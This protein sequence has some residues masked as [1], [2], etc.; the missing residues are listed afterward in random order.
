MKEVH[1]Y[2]PGRAELLGNHTD[3][4]EGFVLSLAVDYGTIIRGRELEIPRVEIRSENLQ[5][6]YGTDV[7][8]LGPTDSKKW[9]NYVLGVLA[10]L[11]EKGLHFGGMSM[12]ISSTIPLGAGLSSSAALE[13]G[14]ACFVRKLFPFEMNPIDIAKVAQKAEH[15]YAGVKCGLLD[16]ISSLMSRKGHVTFIDCRTY[17][18]RHFPL[19]ED[20][21]FCI[22]N[23]GVKHALVSSE[24]NERRESCERAA[25]LLGKPFLRDVSVEELEKNESKLDEVARKRARHVVWENRRVEDAAKSIEAGKLEEFGR[26]MFESHNS[27]RVNFENSCPE[28][29]TLVEISKTAPGCLGARLSG[30]GFGG[31]TIHLVRKAKLDEFEKAIIEGYERVHGH[32]PTVLRT[33]AADGALYTT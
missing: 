8:E 9:A 31:A 19:P 32:K 24:Y 18:V 15:T 13:V 25:K 4:N 1:Q 17:Q 5:Q 29:D 21:I 2:A 3:Y 33:S 11:R 6:H 30:G 7:R 12:D 27:S 16:Q 26:L 14:V 28:L 22:V 10:I 23:S 20:V